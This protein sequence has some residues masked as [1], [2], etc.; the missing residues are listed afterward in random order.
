VLLCEVR[1]QLHLGVCLV[2]GCIIPSAHCWVCSRKCRYPP[3]RNGHERG[4]TACS[5][6]GQA[7]ATSAPAFTSTS[8]PLLSSKIVAPKLDQGKWGSWWRRTEPLASDALACVALVEQE[9]CHLLHD[10]VLILLELLLL[11]GQCLDVLVHLLGQVGSWSCCELALISQSRHLLCNSVCQVIIQIFTGQSSERILLE[12]KGWGI[13]LM[14]CGGGC[15][16]EL[17]LEGILNHPTEFNPCFVG[18]NKL[19][20]ILEC[21]DVESCGE[22][23]ADRVGDQLF[24]SVWVLP[25]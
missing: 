10:L 12:W 5:K 18:L 4:C 24:V 3:R 15:C 11:M 8:L 19:V 23:Q 22:E 20:P 1:I 9:G 13:L 25:E 14:A 21:T 6:C 17:T 16:V 7:S 2:C